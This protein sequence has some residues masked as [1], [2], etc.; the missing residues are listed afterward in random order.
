MYTILPTGAIAQELQLCTQTF[1]EN[2][3]LPYF[4]LTGAV[5]IVCSLAEDAIFSRLYWCTGFT[6]T[7]DH[8]RQDELL[9]RYL[10]WWQPGAKFALEEPLS[11]ISQA[12]HCFVA[13]PIC[14]K[15]QDMVDRV[16]GDVDS[17]ALWCVWHTLRLGADLVLEKGEDYRVIEFERQVLAGQVQVESHVLNSIRNNRGHWS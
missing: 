12:Y 3:G 2:D 10:D 6:S 11:Q 9:L 16:M 13:D 1:C 8:R 7:T 15:I 14:I 17:Q 4:D 5:D